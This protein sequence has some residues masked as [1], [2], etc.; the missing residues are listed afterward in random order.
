MTLLSLKKEKENWKK[1]CVV[2][3]DRTGARW[4]HQLGV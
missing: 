3:R 2:T 1:N 4:N